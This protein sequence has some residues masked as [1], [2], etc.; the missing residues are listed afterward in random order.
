MEN[1]LNLKH[2][3]DQETVRLWLAERGMC[4][5]EFKLMEEVVGFCGETLGI[6]FHPDDCS[7]RQDCHRKKIA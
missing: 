6:V 5:V 3:S 2:R 4:A 7:Y 1:L